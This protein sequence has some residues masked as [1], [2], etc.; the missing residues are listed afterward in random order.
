MNAD[1]KR[2][3]PVNKVADGTARIADVPT[4]FKDGVGKLHPRLFDRY[5]KANQKNH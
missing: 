3:F 5:E 1:I 4:S 2:V